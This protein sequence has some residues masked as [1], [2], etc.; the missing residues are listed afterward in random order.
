MKSVKLFATLIVIALFASCKPFEII[1]EIDPTVSFK[2]YNN[3]MMMQRLESEMMTP[4]TKK[5]VANAISSELSSRGYNETLSPELLV[6][7]M[8][9][10][11][12]KD[13]VSLDRVNNFYWGSDTYNYGWGIGTGI[14]RVN[15]HS[16]KEGTVI[17][18]IID[19]DDKQLVWQ[20]IATGAFKGSKKNSEKKIRKMIG[21]MFE[22]FPL[23]KK[24]K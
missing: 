12:G 14:N 22:Q 21:K 1:T 3:F 2:E 7:V 16:Y 20:S 13:A 8:V 18:D 17:I 5:I 19:R 23:P 9:I 11:Q 24:R 15:Y 4:E 10:T 6:K